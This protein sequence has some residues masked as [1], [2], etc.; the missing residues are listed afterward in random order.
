MFGNLGMW[1]VLILLFIV[2]LLFGAKRL[3]EIGGSL[4]K[5]IREFKG[6]L[7]EVEGEF[8]E[9]G[10]SDSLSD[11]PTNEREKQEQNSA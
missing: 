7:K 5:G 10:N 8:R 11:T 2:L 6:S 9:I 3:P 1:E 4:G